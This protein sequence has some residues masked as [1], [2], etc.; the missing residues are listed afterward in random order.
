MLCIERSKIKRWHFADSIEYTLICQKI[1]YH[2]IPANSKYLT[3]CLSIKSV[4]ITDNK[5][6][7]AIKI[8]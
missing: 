6:T 1:K 7:V 2:E 8:K 3:R 5:F 4:K